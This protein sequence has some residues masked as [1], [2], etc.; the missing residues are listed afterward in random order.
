[1]RKLEANNATAPMTETLVRLALAELEVD[2][3]FTPSPSV[4]VQDHDLPPQITVAMH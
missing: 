4:G 3:V 2:A 1:M